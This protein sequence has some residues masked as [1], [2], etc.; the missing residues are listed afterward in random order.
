MHRTGGIPDGDG[1]R[2]PFAAGRRGPSGEAQ[3][4]V[5]SEESVVATAR[6]ASLPFFTKCSVK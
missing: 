4:I 5:A 6:A 1:R 2:T 3:P